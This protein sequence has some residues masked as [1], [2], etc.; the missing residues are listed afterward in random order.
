M[1]DTDWCDL[2]WLESYVCILYE[3]MI[4]SQLTRGYVL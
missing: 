3:I 1:T 4:F 2:V